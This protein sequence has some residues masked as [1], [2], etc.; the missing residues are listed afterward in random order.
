M[1]IMNVNKVTRLLV[2][3]QFYSSSPVKH[4]PMVW[5]K[6]NFNVVSGLED[7]KVVGIYPVADQPTVTM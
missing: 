6:M 7:A 3:V 5:L 1:E 2:L 4:D